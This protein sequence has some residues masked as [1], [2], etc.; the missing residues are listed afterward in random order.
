MI[1]CA[2][3]VMR[4]SAFDMLCTT[5]ILQQPSLATAAGTQGCGSRHTR[6]A[7]LVNPT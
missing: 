3:A 6:L 2:A 5:V 1:L 7:L 4:A